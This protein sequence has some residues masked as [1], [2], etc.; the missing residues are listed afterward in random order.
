MS[1]RLRVCVIA[2]FGHLGG[3]E[4]WL[5]QLLD[6]SPRLEVEAVLLA[7]GPLREELTARGIP[8][9]VRPT[10]RRPRDQAAA[11][12]WLTRRLRHSSVDVVLANGVKA[13]AVGLPAARL[14]GIPAVWAKHDFS[15]DRQ[16]AAPLGRLADAVVATSAEVGLAT[17]RQDVQ[18]VPPPR[19]APPLERAAARRTLASMGVSLDDSPTLVMVGRLV[20]YKGVDDALRALSRP[21]AAPWRLAVI[22]QDDPADPGETER[23]KALAGALGVTDRV[24]FAGPVRDAPQ[25]LTAFDALAVLTREDGHFGGEG[26][27]LTALEAMSA[28]LPVVAAEGGGPLVAR[29]AG[30]A[31][32][33]VPAGD[34]G[35]V[36]RA[37]A[38]L[39]DEDTRLASG[40]AGR[41]L[42]GE[43]PDAAE[44]A[45]RLAAVLAGACA[46]PGAGRDDGPRISVITTVRNEGPGI[47]ALLAAVVPQLEADDEVVVVDGGSVDDTADRAAAWAAREPRVRVISAPDANIPEGRNLGRAVARNRVLACTD[48][49]CDPAREWLS[50]LRRAFAEPAAPDLVT[51]VY[52]V[53]AGT[54]FETATAVAAYPDPAETRRPTLLVRAYGALLGRVYDP[55]LPTGRSMAVTSTAWDAAGGF[56][57]HLATGED[58]TF[59]RTI[60]AGG[61]LA[62]L[63]RDAHVWWDQ[64]PTVAATARMYYRYGVGGGASGDKVVV[65]RDLVRALVYLAAPLLA[66]RGGRR[67]RALVLGGAA[68]YLS[69]PLARAARRPHPLRVAALVPVALAMKDISKAV[70][71]LQGLRSR[72]R[73]RA[74]DV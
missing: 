43:H 72:H 4:H 35:A 66:V 68:A 62:V 57:E 24:V 70:G 15:F 48:A 38:Q 36:A 6:A 40:S 44:C 59:G 5:L 25:L 28:G 33:S 21:L 22:G 31:G 51:G 26:F 41:D 50:G 74:S 53:R 45:D 60:V 61:G 67:G 29:L 58:V 56:P 9:S 27:G 13:A 3:A 65:G 18:V 19:P 37:L 32:I 47:D 16:L 20:A 8:V 34:A 73:T 2:P 63:S 49:G 1:G 10:G 12:W 42:A 39:A 30:R 64:R 69:L 46:R 7:D 71:C 23:L 17:R 52:E 55:S 11:A 54:A 14:A